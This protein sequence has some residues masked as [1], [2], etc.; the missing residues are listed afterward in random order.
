MPPFTGN[1]MGPID[2]YANAGKPLFK[3]AKDSVYG[4]RSYLF[5][6]PYR[7]LQKIINKDIRGDTKY[8]RWSEDAPAH[9]R[10]IP[11]T[12]DSAY[13]RCYQPYLRLTHQGEGRLQFLLVC[14]Y[15]P[16]MHHFESA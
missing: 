8:V 1:E 2:V 7:F 11:I 3:C 15:G 10:K 14:A 5:G 13:K 4:P 16:N 6:E 12:S 9:V